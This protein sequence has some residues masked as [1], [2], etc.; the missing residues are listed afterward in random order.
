[1]DFAIN[2]N[3]GNFPGNVWIYLIAVPARLRCFHFHTSVSCLMR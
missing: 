1:M 3:Y 2:G